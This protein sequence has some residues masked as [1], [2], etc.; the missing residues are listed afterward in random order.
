MSLQ[1]FGTA[2]A[3]QF[4]N[5]PPL[6]FDDIVGEFDAKLLSGAD[7]KR[8]MT[9]DCD[10][11][12]ILDRGPIRVAL[13]W[14]RPGQ[15]KSHWYLIIAVGPSPEATGPVPGD[16]TL[17]ALADKIISR[18]EARLPTDSVL[19]CEVVRPINSDYID[20]VTEL[21]L[22][23]DDA[24]ADE[25]SA[26]DLSVDGPAAQP[27][28][29]CDARPPKAR[30]CR[31]LQMPHTPHT[32]K[33]ATDEHART[34]MLRQILSEVDPEKAISL[35]MHLTVYTFS[36]SMALQVPPVGIAMLVYAIL[37]EDALSFL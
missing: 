11:I 29:H 19:R 18:A 13:A 1:Y 28:L 34:E 12:A 35:P 26:D 2:A 31:P 4:S 14:V 27:T 25:S 20:L 24:S 30:P 10:D 33:V 17:T 21:L 6:S 22:S 9:R 16:A 3:L 5:R 15:R 7:G 36:L 32:D 8:R 37:R 23:A